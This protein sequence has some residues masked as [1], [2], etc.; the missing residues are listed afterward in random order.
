M[1]NIDIRRP[2]FEDLIELNQFFR[3]VITDTFLKN[4]IGDLVED[5]EEIETKR[6]YLESDIESNGKNRFFLIALYRGK[7]IGSIEFGP[8]SDLIRRLTGNALKDLNEV[9]TVFV[10][11]EFQGKGIGNLLLN[12]VYA[13]LYERGIEEFCLDS[14]YKSAQLIWQKKYGEPAYL[15]ENYWGEGSHHMIWRLKVDELLK[16][17]MER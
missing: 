17:Q 5:I 12:K 10:H 8:S 1:L 16:P 2:G 9:G 11:P 6:K 3:T 7:I 13:T 15:I 4:G 14:G